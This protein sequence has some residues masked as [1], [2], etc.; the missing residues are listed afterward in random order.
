MAAARHHLARVPPPGSICWRICA[1]EATPGRGWWRR[2]RIRRSS[3][4]SSSHPPG[5]PSNR[6]QRRPNPWPAPPGLPAA[7]RLR[8]PTART[9]PAAWAS[10]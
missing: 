2:P 10:V 1:P 9:A 3:A 4:P 7:R 5:T 8:R 6:R